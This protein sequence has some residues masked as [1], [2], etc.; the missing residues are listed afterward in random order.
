MS[1]QVNEVENELEE[2]IPLTEEEKA[3]GKALEAAMLKA[4]QERSHDPAEMAATAFQLYAPAYK[5]LV[6]KL[7][8]RGLRRVLNFLILHPYEQSD[9]KS[10]NE[11]EK[12]IMGLCNYLVE[13]KFIMTMAAM[14]E[15][16]E[17]LHAAAEKE[18]T[19]EEENAIREELEKQGEK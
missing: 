18:L 10:A 7:S 9:I 8:T 2:S 16:L 13:A 5:N 3:D 11:T 6:S 19:T 1:E 15:G 4:A 12:Q 17:Q 14:N